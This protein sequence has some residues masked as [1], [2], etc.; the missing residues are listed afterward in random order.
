MSVEISI[1]QRDLRT[2]SREIMDAVERGESFLVTRDGRVI[3]SLEP[4]VHRRIAVPTRELLE[5]FR[6]V[7]VIDAE[8]MREELDDILDPSWSDPYAR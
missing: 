5:R 8:G 3:G 7:P 4:A 1:S 2:R 6:H